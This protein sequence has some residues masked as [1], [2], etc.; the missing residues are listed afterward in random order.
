[1]QSSFRNEWP[2]YHDVGACNSSEVFGECI[3]S[4]SPP[5]PP[6]AAAAGASWVNVRHL[7]FT[8]LTV[9]TGQ[10]R[11]L[12]R[13]SNRFAAYNFREYAKRRT[14]D[15]FR[16]HKNEVDPRRIQELMQKGLRELQV[17]KVRPKSLTLELEGR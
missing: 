15:A 14:R 12:L 16:E 13:F 9:R 8:K 6:P 11:N 2:F 3:S 4:P 5:L 10:Y 1:M 7:G 17:I